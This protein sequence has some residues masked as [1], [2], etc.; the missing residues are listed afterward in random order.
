MAEYLYKRLKVSGVNSDEKVEKIIT[1][2]PEEPVRLL[3]L[4]VTEVTSVLL[5]DAEIRAYIEREKIVETSIV[6][7]LQT[8][9]SDNR[10][11]L[12]SV[13]PLERDLEVGHSLS[14]GHKSGTTKS[15]LEFTL[16]YELR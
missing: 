14:V 6:Q 8:N 1:S 5:H 2:T 4:W 9:A 12:P 7:F 11:T 13:I 15:D 16:K 10:V 3:E